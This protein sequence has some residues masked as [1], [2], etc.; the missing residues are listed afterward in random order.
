MLVPLSWLKDYVPL[1]PTPPNWSSGSPSPGWKSGGVP[2]FGLPVPAGLRVKPEDAGP[3]WDRD[4]VV[5]A[6]VLEIDQAPRR[7]QA[8]ARRSSTT[9]PA[10]PKTVV[11]GAPNIAAG[12]RAA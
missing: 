9:A 6:K 8:Q 7:R 5:V 3:V 4:K 11:T 2:V 10:E 12:D 1:P